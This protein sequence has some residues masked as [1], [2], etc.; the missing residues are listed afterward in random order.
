MSEKKI[1]YYFRLQQAS[2]QNYDK[3]ALCKNVKLGAICI[4][5]LTV[6]L[7]RGNLA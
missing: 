5:V 1:N 7:L 3:I 2:L 6:P 4:L